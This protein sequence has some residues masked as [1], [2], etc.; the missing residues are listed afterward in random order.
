MNLSK[1]DIKVIQDLVEKYPV[2]PRGSLQKRHYELF[3]EYVPAY[4]RETRVP[5]IREA[6][7]P[8]LVEQRLKPFFGY[9]PVDLYKL[10]LKSESDCVDAVR[11]AFPES[12]RTAARR[13]GRRL[14]IRLERVHMWI[15]QNGT[16]G[17]WRAYYLAAPWR[18]T[19]SKGYYFH[20]KSRADVESQAALI[21]P[22][23]G[24][25]PGWLPEVNF[26]RLGTREE[27]FTKN[28]A[29]INERVEDLKRYTAQL[30]ANLAKAR[31]D[32]QEASDRAGKLM[33]AILLGSTDDCDEETAQEQ[34]SAA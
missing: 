6:V 10:C 23:M 11:F 16:E 13:D 15:K 24:A 34:P 7:G 3:T 26:E 5:R 2:G 19:L 21:G 30:E 8:G 4:K 31:A 20:A 33:G 29:L 18:S 17:I 25:E 12:T 14:W 1:S 22:M 32:L 9:D 28:S 27:V